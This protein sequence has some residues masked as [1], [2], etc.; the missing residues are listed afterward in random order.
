MQA[1][2]LGIITGLTPGSPEALRAEI[3]KCRTLTDKPFAV[4]LTFLPSMNPP[5]YE[6]YAKVIIE[7]GVK[8][9]ETAGSGAAAPCVKMFKDA[10]ICEWDIMSSSEDQADFKQMSFTNAQVSLWCNCAA[11]ADNYQR[12]NMRKVLSRRWEWIC[13]RLMDSNAQVCDRHYVN[14]KLTLP[15]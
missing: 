5:P 8:I 6:Q 3:K 7:E 14:T 15:H 12:S 4:N 10:G 13:Y 11:N 9:A 2:G 1:G